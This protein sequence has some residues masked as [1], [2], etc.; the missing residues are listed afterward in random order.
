MS[1]QFTTNAVI[2]SEVEGSWQ[3]DIL[4]RYLRHWRKELHSVSGCEDPSTRFAP[5]G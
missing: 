3:F 2:L 5:S 4:K 1:V